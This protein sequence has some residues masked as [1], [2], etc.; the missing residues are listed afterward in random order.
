LNSMLKR[1]K[2]EVLLS[3]MVLPGMFTA[4]GWKEFVHPQI[5]KTVILAYKGDWVLDADVENLLM[6]GKKPVPKKYN[7][8][9]AKT[10]ALHREIRKLYFKDY[11]EVWLKLVKSIKVKPFLSMEDA[12]DKYAILN[13][14]DGPLFEFIALIEKNINLTDYDIKQ[15]ITIKTK[16]SLATKLPAS[17]KKPSIKPRYKR[18]TVR[19]LALN[20]KDLQRIVAGGAGK[21]KMFTLYMKA[22][23]AIQSDL[24]ELAASSNIGR[25]SQ[26]YSS[27]I[28]A[29]SSNK[30]ALYKGWVSTNKTL[31]RVSF[32]TRES[33]KYLLYGPLKNA[34]RVILH[35]T[36]KK[37]EAG[38][39]QKVASIFRS[40]LRGRFPFRLKG[41]D[42]SIADVSA[43]F[44]PG[45]GIYWR[46]F[47]KELKPFLIKK[48]NRWTSA[49]WLGIGI[50]LS[51]EFEI[52]IQR[53]EVISNALFANSK[54]RLGIEFYLNPVPTSGI[55][56]VILETN[57]QQY[58][59]R[60]YP[61]E[62][63]KFRWPGNGSN[64]GARLLAVSNNNHYRVEI[65]KDGVWGLFH[66]LGRA[67]VT[68]VKGLIYLS[69]WKLNAA[70]NRMI[71]KFRVKASSHNNLFS[72]RKFRN[73]RVP[74]KL[75]YGENSTSYKSSSLD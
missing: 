52:N 69:V 23:A 37:I 54:S 43:F 40:R 22:L 32:Q 57:G 31:K 20:L 64:P 60:N 27:S 6:A 1:N 61:G 44:K 11:A 67:K 63:R 70:G 53:A 17:D 19:E 72:R 41:A 10:R 9:K 48:G 50:D 62:W 13:A 56:Q 34:W 68:K 75:F 14:G 59:Y 8:D 46:Y 21:S 58:E 38:W 7:I 65:K 51:K 5:K 3:D 18:Y 49:Q 45:D 26:K 29:G 25:D 28:L 73:F 15:P 66:L 16:V 39:K 24:E 33:M 47:H 74:N 71:V 42:S 36:R 55:Q 2:D 35:E 12:A 30:V 4:N